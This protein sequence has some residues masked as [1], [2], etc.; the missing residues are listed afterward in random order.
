MRMKNVLAVVAAVAVAG[1]VAR[2]AEATVDKFASSEL[3]LDLFG[4]YANQD[5][6]GNKTERGGGGVGL[7][8]YFDRYVGIGADSYVEE[9]KAPYRVNGSIYAGGPVSI[10][11]PVQGNV[12]AGPGAGTTTISATVGGSVVAAGAVSPP[13]TTLVTGTIT[14]NKTGMVAPIAPFV[15]GWVDYP[16]STYSL[17]KFQDLGYTE[18]ILP[19]A[20]CTSAAAVNT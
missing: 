6:F 15:P 20:S 17:T 13:V 5:R 3:N 1:S 7:T 16:W 2:A 4:T 8:Y 18:N 12:V 9:W 14:Q 10:G 11:G 19:A